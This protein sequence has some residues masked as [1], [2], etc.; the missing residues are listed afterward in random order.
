[1]DSQEK[2]VFNATILLTLMTTLFLFY[3]WYNDPTNSPDVSDVCPTDE[4]ATSIE[5]G[6]KRCPQPGQSVKYDITKEVCSAKFSCTSPVL[7]YPQS[8]DG[9]TLLGSSCEPN[10][11][12]PC[13]KTQT[14]PNWVTSTFATSDGSSAYTQNIND[15]NFVQNI[16]SK[17]SNPLSNFCYISKDWAPK[18]NPTNCYYGSLMPVIT[19]TEKITDVTKYS[20][21]VGECSTGT[22]TLDPSIGKV[23]CRTDL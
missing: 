9:S 8:S 7:P 13:L 19:S 3:K 22:P 16:G 1:M 10:I 18:T 17:I 2:F 6:T 21:V 5:Q 4:C 23:I 20:C 15:L 11:P 12:C 14:C